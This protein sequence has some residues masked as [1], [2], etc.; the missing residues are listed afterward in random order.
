LDLSTL[1]PYIAGVSPIT[2]S[3]SMPP[4][5]D[6]KFKTA[7]VDEWNWNLLFESQYAWIPSVFQISDDG[8]DVHIQSYINGLGTRDKF[9][10]LYRLIEKVFLVVLPHFE[11]TLQ[12]RFVHVDSDSGK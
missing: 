2:S 5:R 8:T 6:G 1:D 12:F 11:Q 3:A 7:M 10:T 9:P 4:L